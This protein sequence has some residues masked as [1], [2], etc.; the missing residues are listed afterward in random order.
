MTYTAQ[1]RQANKDDHAKRV[2]AWRKVFSNLRK[3]EDEIE[4]N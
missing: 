3:E 1:V 2:D 4:L